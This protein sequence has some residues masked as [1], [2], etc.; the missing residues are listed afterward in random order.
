MVRFLDTNILLRHLTRDDE[1][2]AA[3]CR[4]LLLRLEQG[5]EIVI[6]TDHVVWETVYVLQSP[7]QYGLTRDRIRL[8]LEPLLKLRGLRLPGKRLYRRVFDLYC[9]QGIS[10]ADAYNAAYMEARGLNEVYSYDT[11]FDRI[12]GIARLEP[13]E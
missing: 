4:S 1:E 11:D 3:A 12:E 5:Q 8:L 2:K 6:T 13:A 10:F 9:E 7:R